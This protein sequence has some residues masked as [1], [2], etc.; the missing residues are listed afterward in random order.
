MIY[1]P[2][3]TTYLSEHMRRIS[4]SIV[5]TGVWFTSALVVGGIAVAAYHTIAGWVS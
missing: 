5:L 2:Y 4:R 3:S 1:Y